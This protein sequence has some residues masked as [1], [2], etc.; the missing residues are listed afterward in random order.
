[1]LVLTLAEQWVFNSS[2]NPVTY[3]SIHPN[4]SPFPHK[5]PEVG[6]CSW[7]LKKT[8][9]KKNNLYQCKSCSHLWLNESPQLAPQGSSKVTCPSLLFCCL[10]AR[11][12]LLPRKIISFYNEIREAGALNFFMVSPTAQI[13]TDIRY[14]SKSLSILISLMKALPVPTPLC[15]YHTDINPV[16]SGPAADGS[17]RN[18]KCR[19]QYP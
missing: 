2:L 14:I 19:R 7:L 5:L 4:K 8:H 16:L 12:K 6:F 15:S 18:R 9:T 11:R 1:M 10:G 17:R 13:S 3:S